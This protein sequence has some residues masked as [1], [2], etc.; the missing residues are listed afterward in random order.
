MKFLKGFL[1]IAVGVVFTLVAVL[2]ALISFS[3]LVYPTNAYVAV[4]ISLA[5][6]FIAMFFLNKLRRKLFKLAHKQIPLNAIIT[7]A[8]LAVVMVAIFWI[9]AK[10]F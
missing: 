2:L 1:N 7:T 4:I 9:P 10:T 5:L 3:V 8:V 6:V